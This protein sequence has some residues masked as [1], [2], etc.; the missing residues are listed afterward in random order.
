[1]IRVML[2]NDVAIARSLW[3]EYVELTDDMDVV[4]EAADGVQAV[5]LAAETQP[6]VIVMDLM[7]PHMDGMEATRRIKAANP[8]MRVVVYSVH[9]DS[10]TKAREI[11]AEACLIMPVTGQEFIE[12]LRRIATLDPSDL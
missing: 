3:R 7:L 9:P 5:A 11:G 6:D 8:N 12:T 2:V 4:A 1:M 10:K